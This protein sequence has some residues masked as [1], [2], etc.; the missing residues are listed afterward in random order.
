MPSGMLL[1]YNSI[2]MPRKIRVAIET[3]GCKLNQAESETLARQFAAAGC[4]VV[5][6]GEMADAY[7]LNTC[8]VTHIADRKSRHLLR[9]AKRINPAI[10]TVATGC[11]ANRVESE[12]WTLRDLDLI[13]KNED[14]GS[15]S[16]IIAQ[17]LGATG[18]AARIENS[19]RTRAFIKAQDGCNRRCAYCI[20]PLVRGREK[21]LLATEIIAEIYDRVADGY[22]EV[23]LT[24]AEIGSYSSGGLDTKGLLERIL[25]ETKIERLRVSSLQPYEITPELLALWKNSRLCPHFHISLQSGANSVLIRM[26]RGYSTSGY[27]KTVNLIRQLLPDAAIT[28]DVIVG[29]PGETDAEFQETLDFCRRIGFARIHVFSYSARPGT[30]AATM[31]DQVDARIKKERSAKMLA[32]AKES[33][34]EFRCVF[35]GKT[36]AVLWEQ[37]SDAGVWSGYTSNYI[38]IYARSERNLINVLTETKLIKLYRDGVWGELK[39]PEEKG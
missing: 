18:S 25:A 30:A 33:A 28:T 32:L 8:T 23:V 29:F 7:I 2:G 6:P 11:Y 24:G 5:S 17:R 10:F 3:L 16:E 27:E 39:N 37:K 26:N 9:M 15:L 12:L 34:A 14:K 22:K 38:R 4:Q 36:I 13:L 20:V 21:S 31:S 19:L 1:W 35:L